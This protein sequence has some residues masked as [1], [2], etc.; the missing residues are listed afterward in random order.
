MSL[1]DGGLWYFPLVGRLM[2]EDHTVLRLWPELFSLQR[3]AKG[4]SAK[5][6]ISK[7]WNMRSGTHTSLTVYL[8][9]HM[10]ESACDFVK[11]VCLIVFFTM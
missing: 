3:A 4:L 5:V 7:K 2:V 8:I 9:N 11:L 10:I 1:K 6:P